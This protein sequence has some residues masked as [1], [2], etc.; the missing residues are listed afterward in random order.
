MAKVR[1]LLGRATIETAQRRRICHRNR[2]KHLIAAGE[3]CLVVVDSG[4]TG[5]SKNY[6]ALCAAAMLDCAQAD[7]DDLR[8]GLE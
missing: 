7:L 1:Q 3:N 4:G 8:S 5:A 2:T 6:C